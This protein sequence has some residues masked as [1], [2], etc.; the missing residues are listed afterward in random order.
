[1]VFF[2]LLKSVIHAVNSF[3]VQT[4]NFL[5]QS[6]N[7]NQEILS[8]HVALVVVIYLVLDSFHWFK[9]F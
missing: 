4:F 3:F 9:L 5:V 1:M 6:V 8:F 7:F 2:S